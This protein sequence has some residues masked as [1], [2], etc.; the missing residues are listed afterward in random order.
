IEALR[1]VDLAPAA[2]QPEAEVM[3]AVRK[4]RRARQW[5]SKDGQDANALPVLPG[6]GEEARR[7]AAARTAMKRWEERAEKSRKEGERIRARAR[8]QDR[9]E[10]QAEQKRR[11][12]ES[13][14]CRDCRGVYPVEARC[15][16][17]RER[18]AAGLPL[19]DFLAL[20]AAGPHAR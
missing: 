9:R 19:I 3:A 12:E 11:A 13:A 16:R 15:G 8:I 18:A 1:M 5:D 7:R 4:A 20:P 2:L 14:P 6:G 10:R 17:C